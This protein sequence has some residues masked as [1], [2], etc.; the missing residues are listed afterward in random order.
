MAITDKEMARHLY[1]NDVFTHYTKD[2]Y[3]GNTQ[4]PYI[5]NSDSV[6]NNATANR[7]TNVVLTD[8]TSIDIGDGVVLSGKTLKT[9]LKALLDLA[10]REYPE[11]F[12]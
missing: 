1:E 3:C 9:C 2:P 11:D 12:V 4:G 6:F 7:S 5:D 8:S 10:M